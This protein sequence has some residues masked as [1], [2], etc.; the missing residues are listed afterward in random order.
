MF[1]PSGYVKTNVLHLDDIA[2]K[3]ATG[4]RRAKR[5]KWE[6]EGMGLYSS[7]TSEEQKS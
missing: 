6:M 3:E 7:Y 5:K 1:R 2:A 4:W